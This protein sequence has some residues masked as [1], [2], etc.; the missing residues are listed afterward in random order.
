MEVLS[1]TQFTTFC[2]DRSEIVYHSEVGLPL[3]AREGHVVTSYVELLKKMAAL[4][5]NTTVSGRRGRER[6]G[7]AA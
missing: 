4:A 3:A 7:F 2:H 1:H 5:Y 6:L